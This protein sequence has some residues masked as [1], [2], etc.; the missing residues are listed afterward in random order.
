VSIRHASHR[1]MRAIACSD[2]SRDETSFLPLKIDGDV[3]SS[4]FSARKKIVNKSLPQVLLYSE[5]N[6]PRELVNG[7]LSYIKLGGRLAKGFTCPESPESDEELDLD[8]CR[9]TLMPRVNMKDRKSPQQPDN[10]VE[11]TT[12]QPKI[13]LEFSV[14]LPR[15][16]TVDE[17]ARPDD[18]ARASPARA[19][20]DRRSRRCGGHEDRRH[21]ECAENDDQRRLP[22]GFLNDICKYSRNGGRGGVEGACERCN[23]SCFSPRRVFRL[24]PTDTPPN[25]R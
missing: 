4:R 25:Y 13:L 19:S 21:E 3:A 20:C 9:A 22:L 5:A 2:D 24:A 18:H 16:G 15:Y 11:K 10:L 1:D 14:R 6:T 8:A 7:R 12:R 23:A 17:V